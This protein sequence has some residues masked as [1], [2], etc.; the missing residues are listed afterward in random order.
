MNDYVEYN[1]GL[2]AP[3]YYLNIFRQRLRSK[4]T[5]LRLAKIL[6]NVLRKK[7]QCKLYFKDSVGEGVCR[8]GSV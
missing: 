3:K 8:S 5:R 4:L 2:G 1:L 7:H 6:S